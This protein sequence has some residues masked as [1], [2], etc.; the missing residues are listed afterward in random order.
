[1]TAAWLLGWRINLSSE[2]R[3]LGVYESCRFD[4]KVWYFSSPVVNVTSFL[5]WNLNNKI[6]R[7]FGDTISKHLPKFFSNFLREKWTLLITLRQEKNRNE[8]ERKFHNF[9]QIFLSVLK[10]SS[11]VIRMLSRSVKTFFFICHVSLLKNIF[12]KKEFTEKKEKRRELVDIFNLNGLFFWAIFH[13]N[14]ET[15]V[16]CY[17]CSRI[18]HHENFLCIFSLQQKNFLLRASR[19]MNNLC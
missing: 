4:C 7:H 3:S 14:S 10:R 2:M 12:K 13:L 11:N 8:H 1:M 15:R 17:V 16:L 5:L 18:D 6:S 19:K 9:Q